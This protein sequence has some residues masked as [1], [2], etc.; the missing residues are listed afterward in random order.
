[1]LTF[2]YD[3]ETTGPNPFENKIIAIH[4]RR[5]GKNHI[6]KIWDYDDSEKDLISNFLEDWKHIP[7]RIDHG[8]DYFVTYNFRLDGPFLLTRS[9]LNNIGDEEWKKHLWNSIIHGPAFL[10]VYHLLGDE[11]TSFEQWRKRFGL[12]PGKFKNSEIPQ[13]YNERRYAEIEEYL[14]SELESLE[15]IYN[16]M[17]KEKFF[18]ELKEFR[19]TLEPES[20]LD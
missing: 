2:G 4:Y 10:D 13:M 8:G 11:L 20:D 1:M 3:L 9:L 19:S 5:E 15:T 16:V 14:N 12:P 18:L 7:R 6:F 17:I